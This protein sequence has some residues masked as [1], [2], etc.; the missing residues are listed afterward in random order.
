MREHVISVLLVDDQALIRQAF[1][2]LLDLESD[3]TVVGQA[4]DAD[5][6]VPWSPTGIRTWC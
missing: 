4:A 3:L 5:T 2:A 6:A 1:A